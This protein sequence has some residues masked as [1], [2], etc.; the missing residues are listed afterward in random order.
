MI[1]LTCEEELSQTEDPTLEAKES[2]IVQ[3]KDVPVKAL[4]DTA[5]LKDDRVIKNLLK[6]EEQCTP[7]T[8]DYLRHGQP[9]LTPAMRKLVTEWMLQ[10]CQ[11]CACSPD[12]FLM[13]VNYLD[14]FLAKVH[15]V[16]KTRLQLVG[17]VCLLISSKFKETVPLP[18]ERLIFYTDNSITP[19]EIRVSSSLFTFFVALKLD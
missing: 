4:R 3:H 14:R 7:C 13:A 15:N 19:E 8:A 5:L 6:L 1:D 2:P 10:V 18:G 16:P 11:E 9:Q 12:V 17:T